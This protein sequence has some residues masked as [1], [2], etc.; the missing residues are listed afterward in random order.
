MSCSQLAFTF[1]TNSEKSDVMLSKNIHNT[2]FVINTYYK[3]KHDKLIN[4][5]NM[6]GILELNEHFTG[7]KNARVKPKPKTMKKLV[8][9]PK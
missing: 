6:D 9:S 5:N 8:Q 3:N 7:L 2:I 1:P 4:I